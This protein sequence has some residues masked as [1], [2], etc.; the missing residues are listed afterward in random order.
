M[1]VRSGRYSTGYIGKVPFVSKRLSQTTCYLGDVAFRCVYANNGSILGTHIVVPNITNVDRIYIASTYPVTVHR[2][3]KHV[4][5][6][7]SKDR[8]IVEENMH[9]TKCPEYMQTKLVWKFPGS[10]A[11]RTDFECFRD[12]SRLCRGT[13]TTMEAGKCD[14]T[15]DGGNLIHTRTVNG[16]KNVLEFFYCHLSPSTPHHALTYN[17]DWRASKPIPPEGIPT[18]APVTERR[19][20]MKTT[21]A[22]KH[23]TDSA[24][25][26]IEHLF[27]LCVNMNHML[28]DHNNVYSRQEE[29]EEEKEEEEEEEEEEEGEWDEDYVM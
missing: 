15:V 22:A 23:L 11:D 3:E 29:E 4:R 8:F 19:H 9:L 18:D 14:V 6:K 24:Y 21:S 2:I 27:L 20:A 10:V 7:S 26:S 25:G 13:T 1:T 5:D 28:P 17:I 16:T 12:G